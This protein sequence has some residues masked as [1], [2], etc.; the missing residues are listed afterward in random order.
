MMQPES[1]AKKKSASA[2]TEHI[3]FQYC[4]ATRR[5]APNSITFSVRKL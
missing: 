1:A 4:C 5:D 2:E 3:S